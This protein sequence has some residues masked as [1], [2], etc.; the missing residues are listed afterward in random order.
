MKYK[1]IAVLVGLAVA[2]A[3]G[4]Y[5][6]PQSETKEETTTKEK[7]VDKSK[8]THKII[9]TETI[10]LPNGEKHTIVTEE[11][12]SETETHKNESSQTQVKTEIQYKKDTLNISALAGVDIRNSYKP[13]YGV[14]VTKQLLGPVT[15]GAFGLTN[16]TVGVSVGISF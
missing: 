7:E 9:K 5:T 1:I 13:V 6:S 4:R 11:D 15:L 2:F 10:T 14:A 8:K 12:S 3:A 16:G